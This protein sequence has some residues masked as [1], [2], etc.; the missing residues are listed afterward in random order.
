[1]LG[2]KVLL[3][4]WDFSNEIIGGVETQ[5]GYLAEILK[6]LGYE[7]DFISAH[8]A[9]KALYPDYQL[10]NFDEKTK[11]T[12]IDKY[13]EH[14][15][16]INGTVDLII[17]NGGAGGLYK[18][19]SRQI[20]IINDPYLSFQEN[21]A[22][23]GIIN[24]D[25]YVNYHNFAIYLQK[26]T[27]DNSVAVVQ[28]SKFVALDTAKAGIRT[29]FIIPNAVNTE[30]FK[31][32]T[33]EEKSE[34]RK[35]YNIPEE[36]DAIAVFSGSTHPSKWMLMPE[37]IRLFP[38]VYFLLVFKHNIAKGYKIK[39][40]NV[41]ILFNASYESM[42]EIYQMADFFLLP[43]ITEN[44]NLSAFEALSCGLPVVTTNTG[45]F[46]QEENQNSDIGYFPEFNIN[47]FKDAIDKL[48][49]DLKEERQF[50]SRKYIFENG[51]DL[52]SWRAKWQKVIEKVL[53]KEL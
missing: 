20:T 35:A 45:F 1:M 28:T 30:N 38:N 16:Q 2:K 51:L 21:M 10:Q 40:P 11:A 47:Q 44:C 29:D 27:A 19:K 41:K 4:N 14:Y 13:I 34:I 23:H 12:L 37:L 32:V 5:Y 24:P 25:L 22:H 49:K 15:E 39:R 52:D 43:S 48:L 33:S 36:Y 53:A 9:W 7:V 6:E 8:R 46:W 17:R 3:V 42:P 50:K 31:I 18:N 26:L